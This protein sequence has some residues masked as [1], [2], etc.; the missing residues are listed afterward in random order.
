MKMT[1]DRRHG[2]R[3]PRDVAALRPEPERE[4]ENDRRHRGERHYL[5]R[6]H[7]ERDE[8]PGEA[9]LADDRRV[10]DEAPCAALQ[11]CREEHPRRQ[12]AEQEQPVVVEVVR[13]LGL[14]EHREDDQVDEHERH[15]QGERPCEPEHRALVLRAQVAPEEAAEQLAVAEEIA[16]RRPRARLYERG[17]SPSAAGRAPA[18]RGSRGGR[19][20]PPARPPPRARRRA[21]ARARARAPSAAAARSSSRETTQPRY[22]VP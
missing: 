18:G 16:R 13:R 17:C 10:L 1:I 2:D 9:D 8:L 7:R 12:A 15:R 4:P 22:S 20:G 6:D 5:G 21:A 3:E 11:R 19:S 14:P